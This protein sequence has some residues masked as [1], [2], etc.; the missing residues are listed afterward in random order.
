VIR[1]RVAIAVM[2]GRWTGRSM[3]VIGIT[4]GFIALSVVAI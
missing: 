2:T 1:G 3:A 4:V